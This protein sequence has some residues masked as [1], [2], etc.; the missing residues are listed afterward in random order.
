MTATEG[1]TVTRLGDVMTVRFLTRDPVHGPLPALLIGLTLFTGFVDAVSILGLGRVF[2]ANMTGN[3][4][5]VAFA[6]AGVS[7]FSLAPSIAAL[8]GF[9]AGAGVAG[10]LIRRLDSDRGR[11]LAVGSGIELLFVSFALVVMAATG[12]ARSVA[13][14]AVIAA[15]LAVGTGMQ[16]AVV[17]RLAVPDLTTTVL[18]MT[19]TGIAADIRAGK[20]SPAF[21]RRVLAVV[22]MFLGALIGAVLVLQVDTTAALVVATA[23]L[24]A[25]T[26]AAFRATRRPGK[27][28]VAS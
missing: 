3:V 6:A 5:F 1:V 15:A 24:A 28:R 10:R 17:R 14:Q 22:T 18:T 4:A 7:G 26:A 16:N 2:V 19:L 13:V 21:T 25:V 27:W 12:S 23:V 11:L 9:L 20:P 8:A